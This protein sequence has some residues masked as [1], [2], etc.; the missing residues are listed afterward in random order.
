MSSISGTRTNLESPA[1]RL[2]SL[3]L[4]CFFQVALS[5][6]MMPFRLGGDGQSLVQLPG[7]RITPSKA[8][9]N[10]A[11]LIVAPKGLAGSSP[12]WHDAFAVL[13]HSVKLAARK[14][15]HR[16]ELIALVP[17]TLPAREK[18]QQAF[19]KLGIEFM[20]VPIPVPLSQVENAYGAEV[21]QG[22]LGEYEQLKFYGAAL[23]KY[24]RAVVMDADVML[25]K[26]I[27]ELL[28]ATTMPY[29]ASGVY[30]H[31]MD[32]P[33][34][35]FPPINSGF[36]VVVPN[37]KDFNK[38]VSIYRNGDITDNGWDGSGTGWTY[39]TGSQGILSY[40][41]N[42]VHPDVDGF[43]TD[44]PTKG[45]DYPGMD[46]TKQPNSSRF[47][48]QDRSVYNVIDTKPLL[49]A[50]AK[51]NTQ[52]DRVAVF[53][54]AGG[55]CPK[56]WTCGYIDDDDQLCKAMTK[57]WWNFRSEVAAEQGLDASVRQCAHESYVQLGLPLQ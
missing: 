11:L 20:S 42:Q 31:E 52:V 57:R 3:L 10:V 36:F 5:A 38:L 19:E 34:S 46:W 15:A 6:D 53:H 43:S 41:Y 17:D 9:L 26:P 7:M 14:S 47:L 49:H 35:R 40:Y 2:M 27:D 33:G 16:M 1:V 51:G 25:L 23:D 18:E 39:G 29:A 54:F 37:K 28:E 50:L 4:A 22:A 30:D 44:T 21:L 13:A 32:V 24:D 8:S 45:I 12:G 56:P 48:P 55:S